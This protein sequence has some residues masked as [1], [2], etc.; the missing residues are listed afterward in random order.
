MR[1][2]INLN[3]LS[4]GITKR[5]AKIISL[6]ATDYIEGVPE[7]RRAAD[8]GDIAQHLK[9]S[10]VAD[11][12][13]Y[14]PAKLNVVALLVDRIRASPFDQYSPLCCS[15]DIVFTEIGFAG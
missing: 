11:F 13:E 4:F 9:L 7:F 3:R 15:Y 10:S 5:S 12:P 14:L 1:N 8:V 6:C 2:G